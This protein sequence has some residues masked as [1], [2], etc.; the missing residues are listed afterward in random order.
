MVVDGVGAGF[1]KICFK[2][3]VAASVGAG[4]DTKSVR[5]HTLTHTHSHTNTNST[6][7]GRE[8]CMA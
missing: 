6:P 5:K 7:G 2:V 8:K 4:V 1:G 3:V